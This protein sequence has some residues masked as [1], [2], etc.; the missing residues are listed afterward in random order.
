MTTGEGKSE[1][2]DVKDL[3]GRDQDFVRAALEALLQ[4]APRRGNGQRRGC[5][6]AAVIYSRARGVNAQSEG[7]D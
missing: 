3:L 2:I 6:T 5:R 4:A 1:L 7:G